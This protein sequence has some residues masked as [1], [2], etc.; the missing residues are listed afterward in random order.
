MIFKVVRRRESEQMK[1]TRRRQVEKQTRLKQ[2]KFHRQNK[3]AQ[4]CVC[5]FEEHEMKPY[6]H[7]KSGFKSNLFLTHTSMHWIV[8]KRNYV[9]YLVSNSLNS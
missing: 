7:N 1:Q 9:K 5:I 6:H 4:S 8:P 2:E 3:A